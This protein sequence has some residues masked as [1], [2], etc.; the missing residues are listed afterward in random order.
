MVQFVNPLI[1]Q[2]T[3]QFNIQNFMETFQ[4]SPTSNLFNIL[5]TAINKNVCSGKW[6]LKFPRNEIDEKWKIIK[7]QT[8]ENKLGK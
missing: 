4:N 8:I 3:E 7:T 6:I 1:I 5:Q 2:G